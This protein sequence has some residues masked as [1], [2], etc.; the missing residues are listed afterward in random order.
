MTETYAAGSKSNSCFTAGVNY[1]K[2]NDRIVIK[3]IETN[4]YS[5]FKPE[6]SFFGLMK[7]GDTSR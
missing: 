6:K 7:I 3:D 1:L 2:E 4:R 5:I